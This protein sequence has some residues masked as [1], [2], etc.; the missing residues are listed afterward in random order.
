MNFKIWRLNSVAVQVFAI[1]WLTFVLLLIFSML[2]PRLDMRL[3]FDLNQ[4]EIASYQQ[5]INNYTS[6]IDNDIITTHP[7]Y[8]YFLSKKDYTR[9]AFLN[10][11]KFYGVRSDELESMQ[12]FTFNS[13]DLKNPQA[14]IFGNL[15]IIGPFKYTTHN[16]KYWAFVIENTRTI[17]KI[18]SIIFDNQ[19]ILVLII[20]VISTPLLLWLSWRITKP[21][22]AL[23]RSAKKVSRGDFS[24]NP[25]LEK[26]EIAELRIVG[27]GFNQMAKSIDNVY[28]NQQK[29]ISNISHELKTP[30]TRLRLA[31]AIL[32]HKF[33]EDMAIDRIEHETKRLEMMINTLLEIGRNDAENQGNYRIFNTKRILNLILDDCI[34]E[35]KSNN[36][37]FIIENKIKDQ[38][39]ISG[40]LKALAS[41]L[42]NVIRN[43]QKYAKSKI[44]LQLENDE[45]HIKI[46]VS[47]DGIGADDTEL[48]KIFMPFYR[49]DEHRSRET[50]GTG[51]GLSIVSNTIYKHGGSVKA[52]NGKLGGLTI[53]IILPI[54]RS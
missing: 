14:K 40:N 23:R 10:G 53:T 30:L 5:K 34:F 27:Y 33:K 6:F 42:E 17:N 11:D 15:K 50:G 32:R 44:L 24:P 7:E 4:N 45:K 31:L 21:I 49:I 36:I 9:L 20:M 29:L 19:I 3:Y 46:K 51:L 52:S 13:H 16:K 48:E 38:L 26:S 18:Y 8:S 39:L 37:E 25:E 47:D 28:N 41:S 35:A 1:F 12:A 54:Y 43:A 2:I 22:R